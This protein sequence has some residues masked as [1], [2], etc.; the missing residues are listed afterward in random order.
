MTNQKDRFIDTILYLIERM[1][2]I[3]SLTSTAVPPRS[4]KDYDW[5]IAVMLTPHEPI[6]RDLLRAKGALN[7]MSE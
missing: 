1:S 6:R 5:N 4:D 3:V 7:N 2:A